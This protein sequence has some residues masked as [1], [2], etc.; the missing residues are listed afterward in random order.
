MDVTKFKL[1]GEWLQIETAIEK[2]NPLRLKVLPMDT[3]MFEDLE[4]KSLVTETILNLVTD[5]NL[6][7]GDKEFPCNP[8]NK[9]KWLPK[10]AMIIIKQDAKKNTN[11]A[12][13]VGTEILDFSKNTEN[14]LNV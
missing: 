4:N 14:F 2:I 8:E 7:D 9:R 5:W 13:R 3:T 10:I 11:I 6:K 12:R 1:D